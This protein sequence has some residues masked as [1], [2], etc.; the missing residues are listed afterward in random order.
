M[1]FPCLSADCKIVID[2]VELQ[3]QYVKLDGL[4]VEFGGILK[5]Y[6]DASVNHIIFRNIVN[7]SSF[8]SCS[9]V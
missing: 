9:L 2:I 8:I 6:L 5:F 1:G 4:V 7:R 3:P